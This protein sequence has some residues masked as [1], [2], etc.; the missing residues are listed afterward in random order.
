[1]SR[2]AGLAETAIAARIGTPGRKTIGDI[3]EAEEAVL[4]TLNKDGSRRWLRPKPSAGR[5]LNGRRIVGYA[6]IAIFTVL[7]YLRINGLPPILLDIPAREFTFF[8]RTFLPTDTL[9]LALLFV[10]IFLTV[11]LLTALFGRIWCGWGCPQTVYMELIYRPIERLFEG[12]HYRTGGKTT[13]HPA[14][15]IAKY[16][17][18]LVVSMFLAHTFLAYFVGTDR[19]FQWVQQ[20]PA[21]HPTSF[22]IMAFV[23]GLMM[24]DFCYFREQVC[25][26]MCPYGRFQSVMLDRQSLIISYDRDRGEPRGKLTKARRDALERAANDDRIEGVTDHGDCIDCHLCVVT[27]PT[28]IDIREGLQMECIGCAQCID[29]CDEVMRRIHR[30]AGLIRYSSQEAMETGRRRLLRPRVVIYPILLAAALTLFSFTLAGKKDADVTFL[31]TQSRP[32]HVLDSG[33]IENTVLMKI[34][35]R[36]REARSYEIEVPEA[37][38]VNSR[39][40]PLTIAGGESGSATLHIALPR[41]R[42]HDGRAEIVIKVGGNVAFE[43]T[44]RH[45][46]LGP[47]FSLGGGEPGSNDT[48]PAPGPEEDEP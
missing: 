39:D 16:A 12:R 29:A 27:C 23:T 9:L 36:T 22:F 26:L 19:L 25:T 35:N 47:L 2:E 3:P 34:T 40:L 6:L 7:P 37:L 28:G 41:D 21:E 17:V 48:S 33:A 38:H 44:Y 32:Y 31:R 15:R 18:F 14:R 13:L 30:P 11:F 10:S 43:G 8:G 24:F 5:F 4:S 1:M 46:V 45:R 20:S 42:F